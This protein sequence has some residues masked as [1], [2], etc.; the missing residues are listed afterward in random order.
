[1]FHIDIHQRILYQNSS[2][3][4]INKLA[5]EAVQGAKDGMENLIKTIKTSLNAE[6]VQAAHRI[7]VPVTGCTLFAFDK[8][9]L[10]FLNNAFSNAFAQNIQKQYLAILEKPCLKQPFPVPENGKLV[11]WIETN[12]KI[13]KSFAYNEDGPGRKKASLCCK[14]TGEGKNYLFAEIDLFTGRHHQIRAQLAAVGLR[15]KGDVKYGAKRSEKDGG[16][17]L[18]AKYLSFPNPLNHGEKIHVTAN[19]PQ[20]DN[21]WQAACL[22]AEKFPNL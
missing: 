1:V 19:P 22:F 6:F 16:I 12:S 11:H 18:H 5:G 8:K 10:A 15:I 2:C 17:R 20:M 7:D 21:L 4:V 14:I 9:A 3:I 13:N